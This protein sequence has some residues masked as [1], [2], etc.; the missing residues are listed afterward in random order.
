[1]S[2]LI[3]ALFESYY[4][5]QTLKSTN[6]HTNKVSLCVYLG[7]PVKSMDLDFTAYSKKDLSNTFTLYWR[8]LR[9]QQELEVVM[10]VNGTSYV[11]LGWRP[12]HLTASCRN[13]PYLEDPESKDGTQKTEAT[14]SKPEPGPSGK[15][16]PD[17]EPEPTSEPE[18]SS[19]PEPNVGPEVRPTEKAKHG[20]VVSSRETKN[21]NSSI[22]TDK[23]V[24]V[25]TSVS[26][27]VT[28]SQGKITTCHVHTLLM[29]ISNK[30]QW[31]SIIDATARTKV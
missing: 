4:E 28:S 12:L 20:K 23:D 8:I 19:E 31:C 22:A 11:G 14:G 21:Y 30:T 24:T 7:S 6:N 17:S 2:Y 29:C 1:V 18:P 16:E 15:Q 26:F 13:F 3:I 9:E 27:R 5:L 25:E 10:V